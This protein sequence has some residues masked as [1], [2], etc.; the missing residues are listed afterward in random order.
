MDAGEA[1][2]RNTVYESAPG[3]GIHVKLILESP[4]VA[5]SP[6]GGFGMAAMGVALSSLEKVLSPDPLDAVTR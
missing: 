6:D 1:V 3:D 5:T 4:G 2:A